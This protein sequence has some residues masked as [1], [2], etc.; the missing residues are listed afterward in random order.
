MNDIEL[1]EKVK[2]IKK[3]IIQYLCNPELN[4]QGIHKF[5]V[6]VIGCTL[7][8]IAEELKKIR[9]EINNLK[10]IETLKND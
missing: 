10:K 1:D 3:F 7:Y 6:N 5:D 8:E 2:K 4:K 9:K